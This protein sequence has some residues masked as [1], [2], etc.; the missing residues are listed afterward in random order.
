ML[1]VI[2]SLTAALTRLVVLLVSIRFVSGG[3]RTARREAKFR[4]FGLGQVELSNIPLQAPEA[5]EGT[6]ALKSPKRH[7]TERRSK[8]KKRGH[9]KGRQ[10]K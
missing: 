4:A 10:R 2:G 9:R 6:P 8:S 5:A 3:G 7:R 1:T